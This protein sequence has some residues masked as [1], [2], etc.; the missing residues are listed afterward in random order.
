VDGKTFRT[1]YLVFGFALVTLAALTMWWSTA[2]VQWVDGGYAR[3]LLELEHEA[4]NRV[5]RNDP[6]DYVLR[7]LPHRMGC[8]LAPQGKGQ[9]CPPE[10][11]F[12]EL[13]AWKERRTFMV[14]GELGLLMILLCV[15][16]WMLFRLVRSERRFAEEMSFFLGRVT[17]DMKTP[18]AGLKALLQS[19]Y[20]GR[21][22]E[23][24]RSRM[25]LLGLE[26]VARE[27]RLVSNLLTAQ[28]M[29]AG[30][31]RRTDEPVALSPLLKRLVTERN[32]LA[33]GERAY[34]LECDDG[35]RVRGDHD[36][37]QSIL[38]NLLDNAQKCGAKEVK[39]H[40][41]MDGDLVR[42]DCHDDG[43]GFPPSEADH[44]FDAFVRSSIDS[45]ASGGGVGLGLYL[46]RRLA[47]EMGGDVEASS[48]GPG[49][50]ACFSLWLTQASGEEM[51]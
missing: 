48:S 31:Q 27:E 28:R 25:L 14:Q 35:M 26:Q 10:S 11:V 32:L 29:R 47:R 13:E 43:A 50:G 39:L 44:L 7:D 18:L 3:Q 37:V 49:K 5:V 33:H 6:G 16:F 12:D 38:H 8:S 42:V 34:D 20:K 4:L 36:K 21:V 46:C 22:P 23:G 41:S 40:A 24:E 17:H 45:G 2:L 9:L 51:S 15:A 19:L 1:E 30:R